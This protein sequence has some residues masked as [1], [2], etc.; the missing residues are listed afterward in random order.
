M[1]YE[2]LLEDMKDLLYITKFIPKSEKTKKYRKKIKK[3]ISKIE[4]GNF[5]DV[6]DDIE[7]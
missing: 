3:M 4:E 5:E 2:S 6:L 1:K 7:Y